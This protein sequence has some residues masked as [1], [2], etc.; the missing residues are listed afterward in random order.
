MQ[1]R[2]LAQAFF[3]AIAALAFFSMCF[4]G[5]MVA[6]RAIGITHRHHDWV[7]P[8][9]NDW[10]LYSFL[11]FVAGTILAIIF[12]PKG[13]QFKTVDQLHEIAWEKSSKGKSLS[14]AEKLCLNAVGLNNYVVSGGVESGVANWG[15]DGVRNALPA[16]D[17]LG[18]SQAKEVLTEAV[19]FVE[20]SDANEDKFYESEQ[21]A[22]FEK[23][24][25]YDRRLRDAGL[26][27]VRDRLGDWLK[28]KN[29]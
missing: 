4:N 27:Q 19:D 7:Q 20:W 29:R 14:D 22:Y 23:C 16:L 3:I 8:Y 13:P 11:V 15:V 6:F 2:S 17:T 18:L 25:D 28:S 1:E 10:L 12:R 9:L 21:I 26:Q 24:A 5:V